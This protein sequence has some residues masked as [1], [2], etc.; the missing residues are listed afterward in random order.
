MST[1]G[2]GWEVVLEM[3]LLP[4]LLFS[5]AL[6]VFP[7][8]G[9]VYNTR[10]NDST[11]NM[12]AKASLASAGS[13]FV[14]LSAASNDG[15]FSLSVVVSAILLSIPVVHV[16]LERDRKAGEIVALCVVYMPSPVS[17]CSGYR[18]RCS[19]SVVGARGRPSDVY[20]ARIQFGLDLP[21]RFNHVRHLPVGDLAGQ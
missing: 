14:V 16:Y 21:S 2:I 9:L 7:V 20:L 4:V 19:E 15:V 10:S 11:G 6:F 8:M 3:P 13:L 18:T 5:A 17:D 1:V 12:Y